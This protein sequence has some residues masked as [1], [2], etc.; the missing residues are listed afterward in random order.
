MFLKKYSLLCISRYK[1][2]RAGVWHR[3]EV[4]APSVKAQGRQCAQNEDGQGA[5]GE[6]LCAAGVSCGIHG[7]TRG[8]LAQGLR[9]EGSVRAVIVAVGPAAA[10]ASL[11]PSREGPQRVTKGPACEDGAGSPA[12]CRVGSHRASHRS[13]AIRALRCTRPCS[14]LTQ[15]EC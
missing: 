8:R 15:N 6:V 11:G 2:L 1:K 5:R 3:Q 7:E 4:L 12:L 13:G 9:A 10:P 14:D